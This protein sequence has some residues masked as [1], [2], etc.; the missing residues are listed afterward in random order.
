MQVKYKEI[1]DLEAKL[2]MVEAL[3]TVKKNV[4]F[5]EIKGEWWLEFWDTAIPRYPRFYFFTVTENIKIASCYDLSIKY[6]I[7]SFGIIFKISRI[8]IPKIT[9]YHSS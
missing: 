2:N 3:A 4:L 7:A 5:A 1:L 9:R 8:V 6:K